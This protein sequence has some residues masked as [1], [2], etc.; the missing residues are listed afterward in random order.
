[1]KQNN[2]LTK[3]KKALFSLME[4]KSFDEITVTDI[5]K[6]SGLSRQNFYKNFEDRQ[7]LINEIFV[8]DIC[9]AIRSCSMRKQ[10]FKKFFSV[11]KKTRFFIL[12]C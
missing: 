6:E 7:E 9:S 2:T 8:S 3:T 4:K 5:V 10:R 11:L 12:A 1:M